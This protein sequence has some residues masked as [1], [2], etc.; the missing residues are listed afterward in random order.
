MRIAVLGPPGTGKGS[1]AMLC[2]QRLGVKHISTGAIFRHEMARSSE[3]G[4]RVQSRVAKG[5]LVPDSLV[6]Q[7][8]SKR[9]RSLGRTGGFVLDG[10]PRTVGQARGLGSALKRAGTPLDGTIYLESPE[11]LLVRR[12]S[13]RRVC[14]DCEA[15]YH[16][17]TMRPKRTGRCDQCDGI[18]I[19]RDDDRPATVRRR[20]QIDHRKSKALIQFYEKQNLLHRINGAGNIERVYVRTLKLFNALGW[21]AR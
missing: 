2:E 15:N 1:L 6:V 10:F 16:I 20:L 14:T 12:L 8:M 7:V 19:R 18:L 21:V 3:L 17:R 11:P 13:G 5:K 9:L 4:R